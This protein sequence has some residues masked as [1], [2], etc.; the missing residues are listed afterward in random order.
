MS[1]HFH[2]DFKFRRNVCKGQ[3]LQATEIFIRHNA[4][5]YEVI[6]GRKKCRKYG[7]TTMSNLTNIPI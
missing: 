5:E 7:R 2:C 4:V 3:R 1:I 6:I